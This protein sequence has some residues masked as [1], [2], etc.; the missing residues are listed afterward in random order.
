MKI[1]FSEGDIIATQHEIVVRL[2]NNSRTTMQAEIDALT[3]IGGANVISAVGSGN[4][5]WYECMGYAAGPTLQCTRA[6]PSSIVTS[7]PQART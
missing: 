1:T 4:R 2:K 7:T 6:T 3:L 5:D